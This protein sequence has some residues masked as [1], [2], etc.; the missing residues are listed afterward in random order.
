MKPKGLVEQH[1]ENSSLPREIIYDPFCGS[2]TTILA[3]EHTR[4]VAFCIELDP[5][6]A[7]VALSRW[8][9]DAAQEAIRLEE[10]TA[11]VAP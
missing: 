5:H 11:P 4:R 7:D 3:C 1:I 8:E 9:E 2:G 6:Y 10:N